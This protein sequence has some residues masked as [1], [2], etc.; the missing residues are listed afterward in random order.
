MKMHIPHSRPTLN[1]HDADLVD[2]VVHSGYV[3]EGPQ[4]LEFERAF[5]RY[6]GQKGAVAVH[7]GTAALH[8]A[9]V[10]LGVG[11]GDEVIIPS[12]VCTALLNAV[13]YVQ[14]R[15]RVVDVH[16]EDGNISTEAIQKNIT[17]KVKALI[18]PHMF[19]QPA[20]IADLMGFGVPVVED[21]A[22][23]IG[24]SYENK[25]VGNFGAAAVF[26]FYATKMMTTGEGGMV[27]SGQ[28][29]VLNRVRDE[30]NYD[31]KK[32]YHIR[33]NYKMTDIQAAL[34]RAQLER[35]PKM[36]HHR[37]QIADHYTAAFSSAKIQLPPR[38]KGKDP[39]F[40][41]YVI[42][43]PHNR[44]RIIRYLKTKGIGAAAPV[45]NPIHV[46]LK[47]KGF[48][49]TERLMREAVSIPIYPSLTD[50]E[51]DYVAVNVRAAVKKFC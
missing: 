45:F 42:K 20:D 49:H 51:A 26:S 6:Q 47:K 24:A 34:G 28:G 17:K 12:Y 3:S 18:V 15:P 35:L 29:G 16:F 50:R 44:E 19:G 1:S 30:H 8:L 48:P 11:K 25:K 41:R 5:A 22:Q 31:H 33:Y 43:V 23:A 2:R 38:V 4:V 37:R 32:E 10:A 13:L 21:C 27:T 36:I 14:A 39:V 40:F 7:S 46:Y 9:L